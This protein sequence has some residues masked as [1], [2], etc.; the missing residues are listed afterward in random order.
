M[1][2]F[3]SSLRSKKCLE[4]K[5]GLGAREAERYREIASK[6]SFTGQG[7]GF[8]YHPSFTVGE[9]LYQ[10][11]RRAEFSGTC[12]RRNPWG[13]ADRTKQPTTAGNSA[14]LLPS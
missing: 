1:H 13:I 2:A 6:C 9:T 7:S 10:V 8:A 12:A 4:E 3:S 14:F 11:C 5:R